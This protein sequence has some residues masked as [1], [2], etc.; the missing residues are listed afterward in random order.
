VS[1]ITPDHGATFTAP[2]S[3]ALSATASDTDGTVT[4]VEFWVGTTR[5]ATDTT[6]PYGFSWRNVPAG[7]YGIT[8][9]ARDNQGGMTVS[10]ARDITVAS[11]EVPSTAVFRPASNHDAVDRYVLEIFTAGSDPFTARPVATQDLGRPAI[12]NDECS[13][14]VRSTITSLA[15]GSYIA[16]VSAVSRDGSLR[17]DPSPVFTR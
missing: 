8:A 13:A 11:S 6:S 14:D 3:I 17:S 16:S 5:V 10:S 1:L 15:P 12:V 7:A 4:Q 2:A 9:V